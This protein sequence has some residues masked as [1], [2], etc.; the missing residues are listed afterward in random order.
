MCE[1]L[2]GVRVLEVSL[3]AFVPSAGAVLADSGA[4]VTKVTHPSTGIRCGT[5][6]PAPRD[7]PEHT[8]EILL[9]LGYDWNRPRRS[10]SGS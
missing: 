3:Y 2:A 7:A 5:S 10:R 8:E 6:S 1:P 4:D 9:E